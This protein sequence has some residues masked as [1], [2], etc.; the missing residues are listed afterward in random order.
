[1]AST[2]ILDPAKYVAA[3]LQRFKC[4][5]LVCHHEIGAVRSY[6]V[7]SAYFV[8]YAINAKFATKTLSIFF[9]LGSM[10]TFDGPRMALT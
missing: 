7:I 10:G 6:P 1:M 4:E 5:L 9:V 2:S 3:I 8:F